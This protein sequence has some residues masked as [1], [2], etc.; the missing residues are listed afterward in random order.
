MYREGLR[1]PFLF[2]WSTDARMLK[3]LVRP[4][5]HRASCDASGVFVALEFYRQNSRFTQIKLV[6]FSAL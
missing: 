5:V 3:K 2:V 1:L 6:L 4:C